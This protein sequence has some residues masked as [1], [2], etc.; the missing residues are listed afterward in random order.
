MGLVCRPILM[1]NEYVPAITGKRDWEFQVLG[2]HDG[3]DVKPPVFIQ[4]T[5]SFQELY[6]LLIQEDTSDYAVQTYFGFHNDDGM[7]EEFWKRETVFTF[8]SF[9]QFKGKKANFYNRYLEEK[10]CGLAKSSVYVRAYYTLDYNDSI[11]IVKCDSYAEGAELIHSL[12]QNAG[13]KDEPE[14]RNSYSVLAFVKDTDKRREV[15]KNVYE[16]F[17]KVELRIIESSRGSVEGL[18]HKLTEELRYVE[19][20]TVSRYALLGTDDQAIML[21]NIPC[22][23]FLRLYDSDDGILCNSNQKAQEYAAATTTKIIYP[24]S[25]SPYCEY[26]DRNC[27][28]NRSF[29]SA[30]EKYIKHYYKDRKSNVESAEKKNLLK[31]VHALGKIEY[32]REKNKGI[33]EY[34]FFTLFLPFYFFVILHTNAKSRSDEYYEFL[35]YFNICTQNYDKPDRVFVQTTDFNIRYF[36]MQTKYFTL[37][38]AYIYHLK[39]LLNSSKENKYEFILCPGM[40]ERT[41]VREF[42]KK[43]NDKYRLFKVTIAETGMYDIKSMF[44]ILGHEVSHLVGTRIRSRENRYEHFVKMN[45]RAIILVVQNYFKKE[46]YA[47]T[48]CN[49]QVWDAY[50]KKVNSWLACYVE[51]SNSE[52]YWFKRVNLGEKTSE[53]IQDYTRQS[54]RFMYYTE[55]MKQSMEQAIKFMLEKHGREMFEDILWK[56]FE[57]DIK[58]KKATYEDKESHMERYQEVIEGAVDFFVKENADGLR[59]FQITRVMDVELFLLRECYADLISILTLRLRPQEYLSAVTKEV[60]NVGHSIARLERTPIIARIAIVMSVMHYEDEKSANYFRWENEDLIKRDTDGDLLLQDEALEFMWL[61]IA[62]PL[63]YEA[64]HLLESSGSIIFDNFILKEIISYLLH[65]RQKFY[66]ETNEQEREKL[67]RFKKLTQYC[68]ADEF[69]AAVM[70]LIVEYEHNIYL[71]LEDTAREIREEIQKEQMDDAN[72][73]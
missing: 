14:I 5:E 1:Y 21:E 71:E 20:S 59:V 41:E 39:Q 12:H 16:V 25:S 68:E 55:N 32:A 10:I 37:Y 65:C 30:M 31:I 6:S 47:C 50:E 35:T 27:E 64:D 58:N 13:R 67:Q 24:I 73:K 34:N 26:N 42:H 38:S 44:C 33:T 18:Y 7:E 60:L 3:M 69:Y 62:N 29:C 40:S 53:I 45:A 15:M 48:V 43:E 4:T 57:S 63:A 70:E 56:A 23:D 61:Y 49:P 46:E 72:T 28:P 36:E 22:E 54:K 9:L 8:V 19:G 17:E 51:R 66:E 11:W 52:N 2:H